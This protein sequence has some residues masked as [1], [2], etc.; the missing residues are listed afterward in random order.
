MTEQTSSSSQYRSL[1]TAM[2]LL[3]VCTTAV[4]GAESTR[5]VSD[6]NS[7]QPTYLS[8]AHQNELCVVKSHKTENVLFSSQDPR[9]AIKWAL[10]HSRIAILTGGEFGVTDEVRIPRSGVTLI[11]AQDATLQAAEGAQWTAVS[12]GH[13]DYRPLIHNQGMD[14]VAVINFGTLRAPPRGGACIMFNGRS[15]GELDE[16][17][18]DSLV[19]V[20]T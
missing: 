6:D 14:N 1:V 15:G 3:A 2:L 19:D 8:V 9:Q 16:K 5:P 12:E 7:T 20:I 10:N 11:I 17:F 18:R 13:G 4:T